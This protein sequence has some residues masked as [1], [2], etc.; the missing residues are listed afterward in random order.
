MTKP[1]VVSIPHQL[2]QEEAKR[3][4]QT[5]IAGLK[6]TYGNKIAVVEDTWSGNRL[7]FRVTAL[8]QGATGSIEVE[9]DRVT[10]AVQLPWV[11]AVLAEKA[12]SMIQKQG[13]LLLDH[14][15]PVK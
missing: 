2:G 5:G 9:Q 3:R 1:L 8:G 12:K 10:L 6:E 15:A 13:Q 14:K 4:L 11:L 7:D